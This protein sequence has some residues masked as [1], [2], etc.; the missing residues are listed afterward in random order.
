MYYQM[1]YKEYKQH[2]HGFPQH[3]AHSNDEVLTDDSKLT[4]KVDGEPHH[5]LYLEKHGFQP[6]PH[7]HD[8]IAHLETAHPIMRHRG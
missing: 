6:I 8:S 3:I 7:T 2:L 4:V 5:H 1:T